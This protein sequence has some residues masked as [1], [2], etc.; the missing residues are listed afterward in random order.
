MA[1]VLEQG[2]D[3]LDEIFDEV[4]NL[5][6]DTDH[7]QGGFFAEVAVGGFEVL[8]NVHGE[9]TCNILGGKITDC[10]QGKPDDERVGGHEVVFDGVGD[11]G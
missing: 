10:G 4:G 11:E 9:V 3:T 7:G 6:K 5:A 2:C 8:V 1:P